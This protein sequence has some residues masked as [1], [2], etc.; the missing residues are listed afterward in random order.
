MQRTGRIFHD[1]KPLNGAL[2][3]FYQLRLFDFRSAIKKHVL[4]WEC[5][6]RLQ[7]FSLG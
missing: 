7:A 2:F 3:Q 1:F 6:F 4:V 5:Y